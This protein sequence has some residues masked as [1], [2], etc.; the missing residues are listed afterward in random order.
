[1]GI[2]PKN[3]AVTHNYIW[4]PNTMLSSE[5]TNEP[6]PRKLT[7]RWKDR[8]NKGRTDGETWREHLLVEDGGP[9]KECVFF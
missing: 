2:F 5:K 3:L 8:R 9:I 7:D 6:I 4:A 1:M